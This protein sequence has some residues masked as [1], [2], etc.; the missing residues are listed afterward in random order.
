[1][2]WKNTQKIGL[3]FAL[4][5]D[6]QFYCVFN[7]FPAGN[8]KNE[9]NENVLRPGKEVSVKLSK[10]IFVKLE[11][12]QARILTEKNPEEDKNS[13]TA[14]ISSNLPGFDQMQSRFIQEALQ[15]HNSCRKRHCVE[16]V[17]FYF[18]ILLNIRFYLF[19][20]KLLSLSIIQNCHKL[21]TITLNTWLKSKRLNT[22][23]TSIE[24][25]AWA[26]VLKYIFYLYK[27]K[28]LNQ[29][30][31]KILLL[32]MIVDLIFIRVS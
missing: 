6:D 5:D 29:F 21:L 15:T 7:Y 24:M 23:Q 19:N 27:S 2:V 31:K 14:P 8:I 10:D 1:M 17:R 16:P 4:S 30:F 3:A 20:F 12:P 22:V 32:H 13:R 26:K 25:K 18:F 11:Q 28:F 9:F